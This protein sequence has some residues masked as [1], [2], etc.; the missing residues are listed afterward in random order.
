MANGKLYKWADVGAGLRLG[1]VSE[2][3]PVCDMPLDCGGYCCLEP[4]HEG[5]CSCCGDSAEPGDCPA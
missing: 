1:L 5:E 2:D 4:G 3:A